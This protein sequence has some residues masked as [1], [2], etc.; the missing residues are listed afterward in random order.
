MKLF[1]R[2]VIL[3]MTAVLVTLMV[4]CTQGLATA[5]DDTMGLVLSA[6]F[7]KSTYALGE[8]IIVR[9]S[10]TNTGKQ[11]V[12]DRWFG[13]T[14]YLVLGLRDTSG[15]LVRMPVISTEV[16]QL[17]TDWVCALSPG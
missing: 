2:V 14:G 10:I 7:N 4:I 12:T 13:F 1:T 5:A 6:G 3:S 15:K 11:A 17:I 16:A 9:L 8:P